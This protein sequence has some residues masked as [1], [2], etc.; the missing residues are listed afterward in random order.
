[1][2]WNVR[3]SVECERWCGVGAMVWSGSDGVMMVGK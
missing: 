1:M 3:D 2:V